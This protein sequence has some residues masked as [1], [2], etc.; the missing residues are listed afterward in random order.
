MEVNG[1]AMALDLNG[2]GGGAGRR[3]T[4]LH[5]LAMALALVLAAFLGAVAG[6]VWQSSGLGEDEAAQ[7]GHDP[8]SGAVEDAAA[9]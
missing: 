5:V 3:G 7:G 4:P 9:D 1:S 2:F 6:L 8:A